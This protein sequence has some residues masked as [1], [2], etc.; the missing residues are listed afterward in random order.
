M[1]VQMHLTAIT[2]GWALALSV[3]LLL[4]PGCAQP[5][6]SARQPSEQGAQPEAPGKRKVL[7]VAQANYVDAFSIGGNS[8]TSGGGLSYIEV[9]SQALFSAD[10]TTGRP[11]P[12][13]LAEHPTQ[14][15]GGLR[16]TPDGKMIATYRLRPDVRWADGAPLTTRDLLFTYRVTKDPSM[17]IIDTGPSR[18]MESATAPDDHTFVITWRQPYY[19]ADAIGL[20]AFWPLPAHLLEADYAVLVE[21]Q[22]DTG[23]FFAK[24][25]WTS[26]YVHV[27]PFKLVE[28][29]PQVEAVFDAVDHYFLGRPRLDRIVLRQFT[30]N[31]TIYANILGGAIDLTLNSVLDL[32]ESLELRNRWERDGGG[33]VYLTPS[34]AQFISIQFDRSVPNYSPAILDRL[35]RQGIYHA[36]D[37]EAY[38]EAIGSGIPGMTGD[39]MLP[40]DNPLY[41]YV[42]DGWKQ[43]Y[44]YDLN[45]AAAALGQAGWQRG[46]DGMLVN[47]GG[48]RLRLE[49][50]STEDVR[51]P[52]VVADMWK[53]AGV[54]AETAVVPGARVR[55]REYRQQFPG[56]EITSRG[57]HDS[58]L[59]RLECNEQPTPANRFSGNNRG[60]WCNPGYDRLVETYRTDLREAGRGEAMRQIQSL[61]LDELPLLILMYRTTTLVVRKG[62][63]ALADD[64][65]GGSD[66]GR[67]YGTHS[68]NAH[69]WDVR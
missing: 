53:R 2:R 3:A 28:F 4:Q 40:S 69:E 65:A 11:V 67:L 20:R 1:P 8:T 27:G 36:I 6:P 38:S 52:S 42:K 64:I 66:A 21:E 33:K 49:I 15:N 45:R 43:R 18:L 14:E 35:V 50:R 46:T 59:T 13:L 58:I 60:H 37:R 51:E 56:G 5:A 39:A 32:E 24:P 29:T 16:I 12:R 48:E 61:L 30:D 34:S 54:D 41:S 57:S 17:P 19:M 62:A 25:Y 10:K 63:V 31:A 68:R 55:D 7:N 47:S 26:A 22:K 44:P 9:H 23:A